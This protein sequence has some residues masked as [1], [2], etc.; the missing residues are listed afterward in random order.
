MTDAIEA[1]DPSDPQLQDVMRRIG[2]ID[3]KLS[4]RDMCELIAEWMNHRLNTTAYTWEQVFNYSLHGELFSIPFWYVEAK[5]WKDAQSIRCEKRAD[6]GWEG[7][8]A[9]P[10]HAWKS[11]QQG[12]DPTE[13]SSTEL[14]VFCMMCG[15]EQTD[16]NEFAACD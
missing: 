11:Q 16:E 13:A 1:K 2:E 7:D 14:V 5:A 15:V 8:D 4:W 12:G 10:R 6:D 3:P 9:K